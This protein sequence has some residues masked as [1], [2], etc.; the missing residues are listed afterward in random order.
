MSRRRRLNNSDTLWKMLEYIKLNVIANRGT[1][2]SIDKYVI[3]RVIALT[4]A[5][6]REDERIRSKT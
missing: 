4:T 5:G 2:N 1:Q 3:Q 6:G